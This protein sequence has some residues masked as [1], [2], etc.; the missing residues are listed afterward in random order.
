MSPVYPA[1]ARLAGVEGHVVVQADIGTDGRVHF[2]RIL[3]S[4]P[5]LDEPALYAVKQRRFTPTL[6]NGVPA[7]FGTL[8]KQELTFPP[9]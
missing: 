7:P 5:L 1:A 4:I 8:M 2:T 6:L 9:R 3:S